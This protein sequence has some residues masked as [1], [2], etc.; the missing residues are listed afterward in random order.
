[1]LRRPRRDKSW[2]DSSGLLRPVLDDT[3]ENL[4]EMHARRVSNQSM[5]LAD[6]RNSSGHIFEGIVEHLVV[7]HEADRRLALRQGLY[8]LGQL[9]NADFRAVPDVEYPADR[10]WFVDQIEHCGHDVSNPREA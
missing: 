5:D 10:S 4:F 8:L 6:V 1:M 2:R 9:A 7:R 3:L